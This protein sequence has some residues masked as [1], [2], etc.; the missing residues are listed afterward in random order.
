MIC[1]RCGTVVIFEKE[2][3]VKIVLQDGTKRW[4]HW[5][6]CFHLDYLPLETVRQQVAEAK[7]K[8]QPCGAST[9]TVTT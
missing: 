9:P 3:F 8:E 1:H 6:P 7:G 2:S 5:Q 4:Y